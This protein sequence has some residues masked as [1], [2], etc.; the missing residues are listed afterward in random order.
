[1]TERLL[2]FREGL[3]DP[4]LQ[5]P[6][7]L[8][9]AVSEPSRGDAGVR[10]PAGTPDQDKVVVRPVPGA[11]V[12]PSAEPKAAAL[13]V[14]ASVVTAA[15]VV[16]RGH[17]V[18]SSSSHPT[19]RLASTT[20]PADPVPVKAS[21]ARAKSRGT[22]GGQSRAR[23]GQRGEGTGPG[24]ATVMNRATGPRNGASGNRRSNPNV[25]PAVITCTTSKA[26]PSPASPAAVLPPS[27]AV[28]PS[29]SPTAASPA[30]LSSA[31]PPSAEAVSSCPV[32]VAPRGVLTSVVSS[33][34]SFDPASSSPPSGSVLLVPLAHNTLVA[35]DSDTPAVELPSAASAPDTPVPAQHPADLAEPVKQ[36]TKDKLKL[37]IAQTAMT[38]PLEQQQ[39]QQ[40]Q[41]NQATD[42]PHINQKSA[43]HPD[44]HVAFQQQYQLQ[45][46]QQQL[47][48]QHL[49]T[50]QAHQVPS[51]QETL[52][53]LGED[54][55]ATMNG[56]GKFG[57]TMPTI[58]REDQFLDY[59][60]F[61]PPYSS[62]GT[63]MQVL[64]N[65]V[66]MATSNG[67]ATGAPASMVA[68]TAVNGDAHSTLSEAD[69][70]SQMS[71]GWSSFVREN[72]SQTESSVL[73]FVC[74]ILFLC[75]V[76]N[77]LCVSISYTG[78][79]RFPCL[80]DNMY[81]ACPITVTIG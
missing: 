71:S 39:Q 7:P 77:V 3:L 18:I 54:E 32:T 68:M 61:P 75:C 23:G 57:A 15:P 43:L 73:L 27:P 28:P 38:Q 59:D 2:P 19:L 81:I 45:Q 64:Y 58:K 52:A 44:P 47:Q 67:M 36:T 21:G 78:L 48:Q 50:S 56:G 12:A 72:G 46:Q 6:R 1:M 4:V 26:A 65:S 69:L 25:N 62:A 35:V 29:P 8:H 37:R 14:A 76:F 13:T 31:L 49:Q 66:P 5:A 34:S 22:K 79:R 40:Q 10:S 16:P 11:R 53:Y 9:S 74:C 60:Q 70:I 42:S 17:C 24:A 80:S 51:P 55:L 20:T 33:T 30:L 63:P 41:Q